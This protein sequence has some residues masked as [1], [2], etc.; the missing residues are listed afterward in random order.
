MK[1]LLFCFLFV[2]CH[3]IYLCAVVFV[4]VQYIL[5]QASMCMMYKSLRVLRLGGNQL[6]GPLPPEWANLDSLKELVLG[7]N[8]QLDN[9]RD[10][11]IAQALPSCL[12]TF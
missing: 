11:W 3:I 9:L 2:C 1:G 10:G 12:V 6:E 4:C 5:T 8:P 7:G